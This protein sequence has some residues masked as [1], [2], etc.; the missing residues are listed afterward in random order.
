MSKSI[1]MTTDMTRAEPKKV[2]M[3]TGVLCN[4]IIK[5][6][7]VAVIEPY[8]F[9]MNDFQ[10]GYL[11]QRMSLEYSLAVV[12]A[13]SK[14][15]SQY[16][17]KFWLDNEKVHMLHTFMYIE[18]NNFIM[19]ACSNRAAIAISMLETTSLTFGA[20]KLSLK[21]VNSTRQFVVKKMDNI[22]VI[23]EAVVILDNKGPSILN[24]QLF[25]SIFDREYHD[26]ALKL[27]RS[28]KGFKSINRIKEIEY[29]KKNNLWIMSK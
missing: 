23:K 7:N 10:W 25:N 24:E 17:D 2:C 12:F 27:K 14:D 21:G 8:T 15:M 22:E 26:K 4:K 5:Q 20:P 29:M 9:G 11:E 1:I 18:F 3:D 19:K 6:H 13:L 16:S 28:R